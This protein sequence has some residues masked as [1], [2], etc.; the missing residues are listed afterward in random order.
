VAVSLEHVGFAID[1]FGKR[2]GRDLCRPGAKSHARAFIADTT[3]LLEQRDD[4]LRNVPVEFSAVRVFDSADVSCEFNCCHLHAEAETEIRHLV[5]AS[6]P[7][8]FDFSFDA[9]LAEST[10]N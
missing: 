6:E 1:L 4:R 2:A 3:L 7:G 9:A 10:G 5:F 8:R